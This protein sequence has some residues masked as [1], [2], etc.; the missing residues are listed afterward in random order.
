MRSPSI[1]DQ[2]DLKTL[3]VIAPNVKRFPAV[4]Q[5]QREAADESPRFL[6]MEHALNA[7]V[8]DQRYL[9]SLPRVRR[10][11]YRFLPVAVAQ[12]L[13]AFRLRHRYDVVVSWTDHFALMYALLLKLAQ[14][15]APHVAILTWMAVPKK[16]FLLA[17]VQK[18]ID[19]LIVWNQTH[20]ALLVDVFGIAP[21]RISVLPYFVDQIFWRPIDCV[22]DSICSAGDSRRDY[23]TLIEAVR[24]LPVTCRIGTRV[25]PSDQPH[26][27]SDCGITAHSLAEIRPLPK[28]VVIAPACHTELRA[29]YA[30]SHFVV[31]P[32]FRGF[33][34]PGNTTIAEAMA[35]G[36]A[37]ICSRINGQTELVKHGENGLL[38]PPGDPQA[39]REAILYLLKHPEVAARMGEESRWRAENIFGLDH[40]VNNIRRIADDVVQGT[41][42]HILAADEAERAFQE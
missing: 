9:Q 24:G 21:S 36:K 19:R 13:E 12:A 31:V 39:M 32:L 22:R 37:V 25:R 41:C 1:F 34:D 30:R 35:M 7:D 38:V 26:G 33:R 27:G 18:Y 2:P 17:R 29:I 42:T 23:A 4:H 6:L 20:K 8:I 40:F 15:R 14:S 10:F 28:N 5:Q 3:L 16:A 11:L